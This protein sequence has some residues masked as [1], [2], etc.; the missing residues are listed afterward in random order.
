[1]RYIQAGISDEDHRE[2]SKFAFLHEPKL[3]LNEL[4][5]VSVKKYI[6]AYQENS[7]TKN[8]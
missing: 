1:M 8:P 4:I 5:E 3:T 2:F 6:E 7:E